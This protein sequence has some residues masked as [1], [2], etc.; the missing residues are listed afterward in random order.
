MASQ[1]S[2]LPSSLRADFDR[3]KGGAGLRLSPDEIEARLIEAARVFEDRAGEP[4]SFATDAPWTL[5]QAYS[6]GELI[7]VFGYDPADVIADE[8]GVAARV[9]GAVFRPRPDRAMISR[10]EQAM[11]W[12]IHVPE[13]DR[14]LVIVAVRALAM[15]WARVPWTRLL[16]RP[17]ILVAVKVRGEGVRRDLDGAG[18]RVVA[19]PEGAADPKARGVVSAHRLAM[20]Y[21]RALVAL[22]KKVG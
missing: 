21:K 9:A 13:G 4:V 18:A 19:M 14:R 5:A 1:V 15:G 11:G 22:A 12:I 6:R 17:D 2:I 10:A 20:R 3:S 16:L 7:R 8:E